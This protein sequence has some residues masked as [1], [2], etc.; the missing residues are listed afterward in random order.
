MKLFSEC[1]ITLF[2]AGLYFAEMYK[3]SAL[4]KMYGVRILLSSFGTTAYSDKRID[5]ITCYVT[6]K[7]F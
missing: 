4:Q 1:Q 2:L 7:Q 5:Y 3:F 6:T